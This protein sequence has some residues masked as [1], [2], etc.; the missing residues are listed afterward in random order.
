MM[1][2]TIITPTLNAERH[3]RQC[4]DSVAGQDYTDIEHLVID[5]ASTDETASIARESGVS[6]RIAPDNGMY[7]AINTGIGDASGELIA[8]LNADDVYASPSTVRNVV[9][10]IQAANADTSYGDLD[11]VNERGRT[12]R[13]WRAGRF[14]RSRFLQGWM[15]PHPTFFVRR[16]IYEEY[17][18]Y[19]T[20]LGTAGDYEMMLRLLYRHQATTV[21]LPQVIVRMATGGQSNRSI[22]ARLAANRMD[23]QAWRVNALTPYPW[24]TILKP[25]RKLPQWFMARLSQSG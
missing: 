9:E 21:Y 8:I 6:V 24:T 13:A 23:R 15:P 1:R 2:V 25:A 18:K 5:G 16:T 7:D 3:I 22:G 17:G 11:Y 4:L 12:V 19:R 14:S 20:D 10:S